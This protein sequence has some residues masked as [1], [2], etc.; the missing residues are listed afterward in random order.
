MIGE[1]DERGEAEEGWRLDKDAFHMQIA[2]WA[3]SVNVLI[4]WGIWS[5]D[6]GH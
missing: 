4:L 2:S 1:T 3:G 6:L 5:P